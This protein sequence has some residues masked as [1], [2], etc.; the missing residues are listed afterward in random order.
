MNPFTPEQE[1]EFLGWDAALEWVVNG[2]D[3]AKIP[4]NPYENGSP[5]A[6]LWDVGFADGEGK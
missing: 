1:A 5:L 3:P 6:A 2:A 4:E